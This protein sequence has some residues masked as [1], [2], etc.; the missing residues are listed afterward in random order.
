VKSTSKTFQ[1]EAKPEVVSYYLFVARS[2]LSL[3]TEALRAIPDEDLRG[4][5]VD[6]TD[7][8]EQVIEL[9]VQLSA[10]IGERARS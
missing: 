6:L 7:E 9:C 5:L 3:A 4:V 1:F 2:M 10:A 8:T